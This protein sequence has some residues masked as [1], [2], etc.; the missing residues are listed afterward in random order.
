VN[1]NQNVKAITHTG[2][3]KND[4]LSVHYGVEE[5]ITVNVRTMLTKFCWTYLLI[6]GSLNVGHLIS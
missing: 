3:P 5:E 1:K 4:P 2:V 6:W